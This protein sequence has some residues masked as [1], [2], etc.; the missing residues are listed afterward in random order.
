M[1]PQNLAQKAAKI[2]GIMPLYLV[3][4]VLFG[5]ESIHL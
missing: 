5:G 2:L 4:R 3:W 1:L